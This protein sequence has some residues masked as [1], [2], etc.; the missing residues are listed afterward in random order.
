MESRLR[1]SKRAKLVKT[2]TDYFAKLKYGYL[3]VAVA[4]LSFVAILI[5]D[6]FWSSIV[7]PILI[8]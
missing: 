8:Y 3:T 4:I 5:V 6:Y 2:D 1:V 7:M